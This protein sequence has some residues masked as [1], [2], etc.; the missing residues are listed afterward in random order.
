MQHSR[1][2]STTALLA[3]G[4]AL[5]QLPSEAQGAF[6]MGMLTNTMAQGAIV[7]SER[8]RA[9]RL[10]GGRSSSV[11]RK[12]HQSARRPISTKPTLGTFT[13]SATVRRRNL[14]NYI[15]R[16]RF[17][18]PQ[19]AAAIDKAFKSQDVFGIVGRKMA[20]YGLKTN[21]VADPM[22]VYMVVAWQGVRGKNDDP[23]KAQLLGVRNQLARAITNT[24]A[25]RS[26]TNA[27]K[28]ELADYYIIQAAVVDSS[29]STA[30]KQPS[31]LSQVKSA[32]NVGAR[33]NF[34][35]DMNALNLTNNGLELKL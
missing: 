28:Q 35:F 8:E 18:D 2:L 22:A 14:A 25:I 1:R 27:Q 6:D 19:G 29:I 33:K 20:S 17:T 34:G 3:L 30:K 4:V 31:L 24:P 32:I 10:R 5:I 9:G 15:A 7:K 21:N 12:T 11:H 16:V 26:L 23:N 13:Q